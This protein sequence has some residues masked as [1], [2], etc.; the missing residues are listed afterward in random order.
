MRL[1]L[2]QTEKFVQKR[3]RLDIGESKGI[4]L[5]SETESEDEEPTEYDRE[6][7]DGSSESEDTDWV[8][9]SQYYI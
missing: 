3:A 2:S 1:I 5:E 4:L 7:I 8:C 9:I 6:F